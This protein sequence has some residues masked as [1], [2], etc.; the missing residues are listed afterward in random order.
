MRQ[1]YVYITHVTCV[2]DDGEDDG[3]LMAHD[4]DYFVV[5]WFPESYHKFWDKIKEAG[6]SRRMSGSDWAD[7]WRVNYNCKKEKA[8]LKLASIV[9]ELKPE[10]IVCHRTL[11][12]GLVEDPGFSP[13]EMNCI[14][15]A[16]SDEERQYLPYDQ[17]AYILGIKKSL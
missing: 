5:S 17:R 16:S 15:A 6:F 12:W 3:F 8:K 10:A 2:V 4:E 11:G 9:K 14:D 1:L 7:R 13:D